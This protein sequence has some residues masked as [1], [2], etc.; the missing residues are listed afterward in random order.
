VPPLHKN[1]SRIRSVGPWLANKLINTNK[2]L[3]SPENKKFMVA[4]RRAG[5]NYLGSRVTK[6]VPVIDRPHRIRLNWESIFVWPRFI[7]QPNQ[8]AH[9]KSNRD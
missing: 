2:Q 8:L 3:V 4:S 5:I 1:E 7:Y 9:Q 6:I